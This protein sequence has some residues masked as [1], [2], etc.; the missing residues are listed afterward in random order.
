ME[1]TQTRGTLE[2]DGVGRYRIT[3]D[4]PG[5]VSLRS[6]MPDSVEMAGESGATKSDELVFWINVTVWKPTGEFRD[7]E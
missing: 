7:E 3:S 1:K 5:D 4:D 2:Y 6:I